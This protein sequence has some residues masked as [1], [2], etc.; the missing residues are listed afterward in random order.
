MTAQELL[1]KLASTTSTDV[2]VDV[3][4]G[5]YIEAGS[6]ADAYKDVQAE[7]K[8]LLGEI[9]LETGQ[10]QLAA[11]CGTAKI[12]DP[13]VRVSYDTKALD[14]LRASSDEYARLLGPHRKETVVD[15]SMR[16]TANRR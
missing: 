2:A 14:A 11:S 9:M 10:T 3:A 12:T 15:G 1:A 5:V 4:I 13:S 6:A 8:R 16:I 7:A